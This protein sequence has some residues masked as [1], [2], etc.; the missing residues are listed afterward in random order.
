VFDCDEPHE[1][2]YG[3]TITSA[4]LFQRAAEGLYSTSVD[5]RDGTLA[6]GVSRSP[7]L[8][9]LVKGMR[10]GATAHLTH[11]PVLDWGEW[12]T[13]ATGVLVVS[14]LEH[15]TFQAGEPLEIGLQVS[16]GG[17]VDFELVASATAR[18]PLVHHQNWFLAEDGGCPPDVEPILGLFRSP[19]WLRRNRY[20]EAPVIVP[21]QRPPVRDLRVEA[22]ADALGGLATSDLLRSEIRRLLPPWFVDALEGDRK[23]LLAQTAAIAL[24][25]VGRLLDELAK[26][27]ANQIDAE[28]V[29]KIGL[30]I[31]TDAAG[32]K[33]EVL[34]RGVLRQGLQVIAGGESSLA[35]K[36]AALFTDGLPLTPE[37]LLETM[38]KVVLW[39]LAYGATGGH[40]AM[41]LT[42]GRDHYRGRLTIASQTVDGVRT[43]RLQASLPARVLDAAGAMHE[44]VLRAIAKDAWRGELRANPAWSPL[45]KRITVHSQGGCPMGADAE[46]SVTDSWGQ[47]HGVP[48]LFIMDAAAFPTSVGVNPSAT[49]A[50]V[51]EYKI[52]RFIRQDRQQPGWESDDRQHAARWM[53]AERRAALDPLNVRTTPSPVNVPPPLGFTFTERME[54][55]LGEPAD[56]SVKWDELAS[57]PYRLDP[58]REAEALGIHEGDAISTE[59]VASVA[60]LGEL[61]SPV[62]HTI[63]IPLGGAVTITRKSARYTLDVGEGSFLQLFERLPSRPS[64]RGHEG[65]PSVPTRFFRYDLTLRGSDGGRLRGLKVLQDGPGGDLWR[66]TSTVYFELSF[67]P[68]PTLG[69]LRVS[70]ERFLREQLP[71]MNVAGT[72]DSARRSWALAAFYKYFAS[73]LADVYMTRADQLKT[74]VVNLLT[75]IHV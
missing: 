66:D 28:L 17:N 44:R 41:L 61:V 75:T 19:L 52:E 38:G 18:S 43:E 55:F 2:D 56:A 58:F 30:G 64:M 13:G 9:D 39:A 4:L 11:D 62:G 15:G 71:S 40:T 26:T 35:D 53:T 46:E 49:V 20:R 48:G 73:E 7:M 34:V 27:L 47:V 59:L 16:R 67:G 3:P 6:G 14:S 45:T 60:D 25:M 1:A 54:G 42:M 22:F 69:I 36:A 68:R 51:A 50:A 65:A 31:A 32:R 29:S 33:K 8:G 74:L 70:L 5:F 23:D 10:S 57:F 24:P 12:K 37:K 72:E 21:F 63:K